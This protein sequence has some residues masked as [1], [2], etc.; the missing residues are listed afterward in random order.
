MPLLLRLLLLLLSLSMAP[1]AVVA[2][3]VTCASVPDLGYCN[4]SSDAG[5]RLTGSV[6]G[7]L[8]TDL[9]ERGRIVQDPLYELGFISNNTFEFGTLFQV[10]HRPTNTVA[11]FR[12]WSNGRV[13]VPD[14]EDPILTP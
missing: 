2:P 4:L 8:I 7:H 13:Q 3:V 12:R 14:L 9:E 11:R 1:V 10:T 6:P 5:H